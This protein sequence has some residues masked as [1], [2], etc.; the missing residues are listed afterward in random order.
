MHPSRRIARVLVSTVLMAVA[1]PAAPAD[2]DSGYDGLLV[3]PAKVL[4]ARNLVTQDGAPM[5]FPRADR[6]RLQLVFFGYANCP[7]VC[8]ATMHKVKALK[9]ALGEAAGALDFY[10]VSVDPARDTPAQLKEFLAR[11]DPSVTGLTGETREVQALQN[12]FGVLT[13]KFQGKSAF[14]YTMQHSV[15]LYLLDRQGRLRVMY[16]ASAP[17]DAIRRDITRLLAGDGPTTGR[18]A[19]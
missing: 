8:P 1:L 16:P 11:Y 19:G 9:A 18:G 6:G 12:E 10:I 7:D 4:A 3:E 5:R 14:A 17:I 15:F 2:P 13:R